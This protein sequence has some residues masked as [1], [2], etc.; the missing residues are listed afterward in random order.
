[1]KAEVLKGHL[2]ALVLAALE[3]E[4]AHGY[5]IIQRLSRRSDDVFKLPEGTIY[6]ALHRLERDGLVTSRWT[7]ASGRKRRVYRITR[8]GPGGAR[9][10]E[11]R[12]A[13]VL[14]RGRG[15]V[16]VTYLEQLSAELAAVGIRGRLRARIVAEARDHLAEGD[17][18]RF[19]DPAD[20]ARQF[21]D[22]LALDRSRRAAFV[23]FGALAAA[24][25]G[26]AA[27][28]L[29]VA[30]GPQDIAAGRWAPLGVAAALGTIV[31]PQVAFAA[32]VLA[33]LRALRLRGAAAGDRASADENPGRARLRRAGARLGRR[34]RDRV[35]AGR[36]GARGRGCTAPPA[37]CRR[38]V[39]TPRC[40]GRQVVRSGRGGRRLRRSARS[41]A[42]P[43]GLLCAV[44][45]GVAG[46]RDLRGR[47]EPRGHPERRLPR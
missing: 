10:A 6:P 37:R 39:L 38:G 19:G 8:S 32:G 47:P 24:G 16:R 23:A 14:A 3:Q 18:E 15:G 25:A 27:M 44:T 40:C 36:V 41:P 7:A 29:A 33:L 26:F 34:L 9:G 28:W 4:P 35:P 21:A 30:S 17:E 43:P 22:G 45:A 1:M 42:A 13:D 11:A 46:S 20:L 31:F 12:V 5:A 2:D